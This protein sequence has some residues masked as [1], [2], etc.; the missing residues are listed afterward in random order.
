MFVSFFPKPKLFFLSAAVWSLALVLFWFN[1]GAELGSLFGL[2]PAAPDA[3]P[4]I[5]ISVFW[6]KPFLWFYI[7]YAAAV[8]LFYAF[9]RAYSP[10]PWEEWS[11]LVSA[12]ILF[13]IYFSVQVSVAVN[14]WYGPFF[15]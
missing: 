4:I 13:L 7:Y 12:L 9:W 5:G 8:L 6:S 15:D 1:G 2:P 10:H 11:I 3:P 14:N